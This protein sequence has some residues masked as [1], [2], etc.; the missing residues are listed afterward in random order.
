MRLLR[1]SKCPQSPDTACDHPHWWHPG[2]AVICLV[3]EA[4]GQNGTS[5]RCSLFWLLVCVY[6]ECWELVRILL[7]QKSRLFSEIVKPHS[8]LA[9]SLGGTRFCGREM[10]ELLGGAPQGCLSP[11]RGLYT[12]D[13][14]LPTLFLRS[15]LLATVAEP[16]S[17]SESWAD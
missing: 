13:P 17:S 1:A 2:E 4:S 16:H 7:P 8:A 10:A 11:T 6:P 12:P 5:H 15:C 14:G 9:A 3:L